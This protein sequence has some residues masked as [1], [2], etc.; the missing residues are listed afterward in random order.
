M[1]NVGVNLFGFS[2]LVNFLT[3]RVENSLLLIPFVA[4]QIDHSLRDKIYH[5]LR[6]RVAPILPAIVGS[7]MGE[8]CNK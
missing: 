3:A 5:S 6:D 7:K 1:F 4:W 8:W 2:G